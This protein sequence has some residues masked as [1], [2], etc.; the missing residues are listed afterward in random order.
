MWI[1]VDTME[2]SK[3]P[4]IEQYKLSRYEIK[5]NDSVDHWHCSK[6][7]KKG[8]LERTEIAR[9]QAVLSLSERGDDKIAAI[10]SNS[11]FKFKRK[12]KNKR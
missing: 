6:N 9:V 8:E 7:E 4:Q 10:L 12:K 1:R 11:I 3:A 2:Q 5:A